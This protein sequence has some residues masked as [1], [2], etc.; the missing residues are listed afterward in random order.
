MNV[1]STLVSSSQRD[2][3]IMTGG[4]YNAMNDLWVK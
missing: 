4:L 1:T 3:T 2:Y